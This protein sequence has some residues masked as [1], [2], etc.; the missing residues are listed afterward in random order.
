MAEV[1][2]IVSF[3]SVT[4]GDIC[5]GASGSTLEEGPRWSQPFSLLVGHGSLLVP[6]S[7]TLC[8]FSS[9]FHQQWHPINNLKLPVVGILIPQKFV[10][11]TN[12]GFFFYF[13]DSKLW[14]IYQDTAGYMRWALRDLQDSYE[15]SVGL[16]P[17]ALQ[18][19]THKTR[20]SF[21]QQHTFFITNK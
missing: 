5:P 17:L 7:R 14:D 12:C 9:Q 11:T 4:W 13:L 1:I 6:A 15:Y 16:V 2:F 18:S 19:R 20:S 3:Y 10:S 21:H 8:A